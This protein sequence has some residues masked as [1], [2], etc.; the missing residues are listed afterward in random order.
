MF[1]IIIPTYNRRE[2]LRKCLQALSVQAYPISECEIIVVDDGS[3]DNS[4]DVVEERRQSGGLNLK[5]FFQQNKGPSAARNVGIRNATMEHLLFLGDDI[6]GREDLLGQHAEWQRTHPQE[7]VA[8]LG[9]VTWSP[10]LKVDNFM[11]WLVNSGPQNMFYRIEDQIEVSDAGFMESANLSLKAAFLRKV[12]GFDESLRLFENLELESRL[13]EVGMRLLYNKN[14][15]G[16]HYHKVTMEA[17]IGRWRQLK[18]ERAKLYQKRPELIP[19]LELRKGLKPLLRPL[20][21]NRPVV[22]ILKRLA[23][24]LGGNYRMAR[25]LYPRILSY[26]AVKGESR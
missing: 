18:G 11:R 1:S 12:G 10:Q 14:A 4:R 16:F 8:V 24:I 17:A 21:R 19:P 2:T 13:R 26:Y 15:V 7:E 9:Y 5:Y 23:R 22:A 6:I 25:L 20:W 3:Q